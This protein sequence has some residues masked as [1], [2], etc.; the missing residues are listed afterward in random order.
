MLLMCVSMIKVG[1]NLITNR[2][3]ALSSGEDE[4]GYHLWDN[5]NQKMIHS[6][7]VIFNEKVMYKDKNN[8][9]TSNPEQSGPIYVEVDDVPETP[10]VESPQLDESTKH[11]SDQQLDRPKPYTLGPIFLY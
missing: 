5:E 6:R 7:D 3:S 4:F 9:H 8:T 11:S 10:I 2:K 1:I